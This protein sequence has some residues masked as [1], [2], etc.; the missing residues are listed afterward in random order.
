MVVKNADT[1]TQ[2][3]FRD[4]TFDDVKAAALARGGFVHD[5]LNHVAAFLPAPSDSATAR[6]LVVSFDNLSAIRDPRRMPWEANFLLGQNWSILGIM[7][8][9]NDWYRHEDVWDLFDVLRREK[10]FERFDHVAM[11]GASM[12]GYGAL[13]FAPAAPGCTVL[14]FAPQSTLDPELV[15]FEKRYRY[16]RKQG[17]WGGRYTDA[18]DGVRA[19]KRAYILYDPMERYDRMHVE[20]LDEPNVTTLKLPY[21]GHKIPLQLKRMGILKSL[22]VPALQGNLDEAAFHRLF[23]ARRTSLPWMVGFLNRCLEKGHHHAGL[24]LSEKLMENESNWKLRKQHRALQEAVAQTRSTPP[25][26][27]DAAE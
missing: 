24:A 7:G 11:Y 27:S 19:A 8:R 6:N 17:N 5:M 12:G 26:P 14:A 22:A 18:A 9:I 20:R 10:F 1:L 16:G 23:R 13:T 3:H 15:P 25:K 2:G 21:L 4:P